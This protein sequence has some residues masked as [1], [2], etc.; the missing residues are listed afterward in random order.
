VRIS[1]HDGVSLF[2]DDA[3]GTGAPVVFQHGLGGDASQTR[4]VFPAS[5]DLRMFTVEC[6]CHGRSDPG[7]PE[8]FALATVSDDVAAFV[9]QNFNKPI[10]IGGIS[11]GAAIALRIAV[12]SPELVKGVILGRPAWLH[13]VAPPNLSP[14]RLVADL[15]VRHGPERAREV[16]ERSSVV[17]ELAVAAPDNLESLRGYFRRPDIALFSR[18]LAAIAGDGPNVTETEL[19]AIG[20]PTLVVGTADDLLHPLAFAKALADVIPYAELREIT[21]KVQSR[22]NYALEFGEAIRGFIARHHLGE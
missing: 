9:E 11:M 10:V 1:T 17:R 14:I 8:A 6:R 5:P 19:A 21:S 4:D 15:V 16:F 2:V 18:M 3:G 13:T 22:A 12:K 20:V 7:R